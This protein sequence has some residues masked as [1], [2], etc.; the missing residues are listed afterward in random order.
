MKILITERQYNKLFEQDLDLFNDTIEDVCGEDIDYRNFGFDFKMVYINL[1]TN[2]PEDR[3]RLFDRIKS[4]NCDIVL[5]NMTTGEKFTLSP[6]DIKITN[7]QNKKLYINKSVYNEKIY[8]NLTNIEQYEGYVKSTPIKKALEMAFKSNWKGRDNEYVAGV[9]GVLPIKNDPNEWSIVNFFNSKESVK[10]QIKIFLVRDY[11]N[12]KFIP[13]ENIE[14][15]V[16]NW[17]VN[18]FEDI[19]S[20]DMEELVSIQEKSIMD[21]YAVELKDANHIQ[22]KYHPNKKLEISGFGTIRDIEQGIDAT[23]DGVTYQIKPLSKVSHKDDSI[24]VSIGYSN[25]NNYKDR[26]VDRMAFVK[27][28]NLYVFNN[29][30]KSLSGNTYEFDKSDLIEPH[31]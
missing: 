7:T 3:E 4:S 16:I 6:D 31:H 5:N 29:N 18:L 26:P 21:N 9:V 27:G 1:P 22:K 20:S 19:N 12:G 14:E 30:A 28:D 17:M 24:F 25:A 23:I 15:S 10:N 11:R 8:P 2:S 13:D